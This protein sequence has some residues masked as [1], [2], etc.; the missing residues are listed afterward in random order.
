MT[1]EASEEKPGGPEAAATKPWEG[2]PNPDEAI[3]ILR[4]R[5][6]TEESRQQRLV[7]LGDR[8]SLYVPAMRE[9]YVL[10]WIANWLEH[11]KIEREKP[12]RY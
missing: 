7:E 10:R 5:A 11:K 8:T 1:S 9:A 12:R 6:Y 3:E 4:K 2:K